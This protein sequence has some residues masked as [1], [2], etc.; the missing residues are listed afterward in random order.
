MNTSISR[1]TIAPLMAVVLSMAFFA[2]AQAE[3]VSLA[4]LFTSATSPLASG[5][6]AGTWFKVDNNA[7][8]SEATWVTNDVLETIKNTTWGTGIWS[9]SDI[10]AIAGDPRPGYVTATT[11]TVGAVSFANNIYNDTFSSGAF[12]TWDADYVRPLAP[13]VGSANACTLANQTDAACANEQNYAGVFTGFVYV[14][15]AGLYDFGVFADDVFSF[16]LNGLDSFLGMGREAVAG[17]GNTGRVLKSLL[18]E[19][20]LEGLTLSEGFY[21][22]D[23][24]YANRLEAGVIDLGW[25]LPG[26][27]TWS[28]PPEANLFHPVSE[29]AT[30]V[31]L[32]VGLFG[33]WGL[34][35]R[36][37]CALAS[38]VARLA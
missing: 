2:A 37:N 32:T 3:P 11:T 36:A 33:L 24:S 4:P 23:L 9:A 27:T 38:R 21:G 18:Q 16:K 30:L 34:R 25:K 19:N 26:A 28:P 1:A 7:R 10:A 14:A 29:P 13:I 15:V 12:G 31:L 6:L 20:A 5:G 35:K 17:S 22:I 8:F